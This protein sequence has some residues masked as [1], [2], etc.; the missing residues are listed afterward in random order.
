M[1]QPGPQGHY[2]RFRFFNDKKDITAKVK[3]FLKKRGGNYPAEP[4]DEADVEHGTPYEK[5]HAGSDV[6]GVKVEV[7]MDSLPTAASSDEVS[8]PAR[9]YARE[10]ESRA[11]VTDLPEKHVS[12]STTVTREADKPR[13]A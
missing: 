5:D 10:V 6:V 7:T 11:T 1:G 3:V 13:E 2:T 8:Q 4:D 9:K 12:T